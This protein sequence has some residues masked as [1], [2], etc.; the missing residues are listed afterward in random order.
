MQC[1]LHK[2]TRRIP[3]FSNLPSSPFSKSSPSLFLARHQSSSSPRTSSCPSR[4][5]LLSDAALNAQLNACLSCEKKP[6]QTACPVDC[7]PADFIFAART[8]SSD[9][10]QP[11]LAAAHILS[12]NPLGGSCGSLCPHK[13]CVAACSRSGIDAPID[14][15]RVQATLV[16]K[17][18]K[19][20]KEEETKNG[21]SLLKW[22]IRPHS[23]L[24]KKHIAVIGG[25]PSGLACA[26]KLIQEGN[27]VTLFDKDG[28]DGFGGALAS[29]IPESR[30]P[31]EILEQDV[32]FLVD[33][34][35]GTELDI[36]QKNV[37]S[38]DE[39]G[40]SFDACVIAVGL[41]KPL[42]QEILKGVSSQETF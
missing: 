19:K 5:P 18:R 28:R 22:A 7:S 15:P 40:S 20:W 11:T 17:A 2:F 24:S 38:L 37:S 1:F 41:W 35:C 6:C 8:E 13:F 21:N 27:K 25:G 23:S 16:S 14:I 34:V 9:T 31:S 36:C 30:F 10:I 29:T 42:T 32:Q 26:A 3:S 12:Q 4:N 33:K 39:L